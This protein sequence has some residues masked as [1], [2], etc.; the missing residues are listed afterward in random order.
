MMTNRTQYYVRRD[1]TQFDKKINNNQTNEQTYGHQRDD[2]FRL[3][4]LLQLALNAVYD[5][6]T[7]RDSSVE[8]LQ[9]LVGRRDH[10]AIFERKKTNE[11][12]CWKK[13]RKR[14]KQEILISLLG[15][16]LCHQEIVSVSNIFIIFFI[17]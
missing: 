5:D 13:E 8:R 15:G 1:G 2:V 16:A 3:L 6:Q 7:V 11:R 17:L 4:G 14:E 9:Q 12:K 10:A